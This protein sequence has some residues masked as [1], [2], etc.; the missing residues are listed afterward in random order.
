[1]E[2]KVVIITGASS[3]IGAALARHL[4]GKGA[5]LALAARNAEKLTAVAEECPQAIAIPTDVSDLAACRAMVAR[6]V[7]AYGQIDVLVNNAGLSML[8]RFDEL[9]DLSLFETLMRVNYFGAVYCTQAALPHLKKT[10]GLVVAISTLAGVTGV[11]LRTGYSAAKHAL[12]GF[13][14][15]LRIELMDSGVDVCM[16]SP[17]FVDTQIR[18]H[19]LGGDGSPLGYNPLKGRKMMSPEEAAAI[20]AKAIA[21]RKREVRMGTRGKL[22]PLGKLLIPGVVDRIA[23]RSADHR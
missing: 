2:G 16:V 11:P 6:T 21:G 13:M 17:G 20:I 15:S 18:E 8:A 19:S 1:M 7:E 9:D 5:K 22:L 3:G 12:Q 23:K 4:G 14:D 10:E